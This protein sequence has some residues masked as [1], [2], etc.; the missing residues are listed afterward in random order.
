MGKPEERIRSAIAAGYNLPALS[1]VAMEAVELASQ[2]GVPASRLS[3][4]IER[5]P[6]LAARLLK[7]ANSAFFG[8]GQPVGTLTQAIVK[9]GFD[10]VR[11]MALSISLRDTFPMGQKGPMDYEK[12]WKISLYRALIAKALSP[13]FPFVHPDEAFMAALLEEIG[14][15]V[16]YDLF[17]KDRLPDAPLDLDALDRLLRWEMENFGVNHRQVGR[18]VLSQWAFPERIL[19]CQAA[20]I[21]SDLSGHVPKEP[22]LHL[23]DVASFLAKIMTSDRVDLAVS[24]SRAAAEADIL[25]EDVH[26]ILTSVLDEVEEIG[27]HLRIQVD[28]DKDIIALLEKANSALMRISQRLSLCASEESQPLPTLN[29]LDGGPSSPTEV[30]QAVVHEIRNPLMV[31]GGFVRRLA[32]SLAPDSEGNRYVTVILDEAARIERIMGEMNQKFAKS[33]DTR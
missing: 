18:F 28:Q 8:S 15:L 26:R 1:P 3:A 22:I 25:F 2:D 10:R 20:G 31:V 24:L 32:K 12:F 30:L 19:L 27:S 4:V 23:C 33:P 7:L 29:T 5:D 9:V 6:S 11:I 14:L 17:L 21:H 13:R 16:F